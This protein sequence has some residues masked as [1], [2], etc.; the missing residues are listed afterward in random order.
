MYKGPQYCRLIQDMHQGLAGLFLKEIKNKNRF[1]S[2]KDETE[3]PFLVVAKDYIT[4]N[5]NG[6]EMTSIWTE[7]VR[8]LFR[9]PQATPMLTEISHKS[10]ETLAQHTAL[11]YNFL[12][13]N[14]KV[15]V[16]S[17]S[18]WGKIIN[19]LINIRCYWI[20]LNSSM[21]QTFSEILYNRE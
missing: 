7:F 6:D 12:D 16:I 19:L 17:S 21:T 20:S 10:V 14:I 11:D 2:Q 8:Y 1:D 13:Y 15:R 4:E 9:T 18:K 3:F 5:L